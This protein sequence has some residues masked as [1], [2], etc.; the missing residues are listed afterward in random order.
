MD[1]LIAFI[2]GV[3]EGITEFVPISSTGHLIIIDELLLH[4]I[5]RLQSQEV[6]NTFKIVIQFGAVLAVIVTNSNQ[7][8][9]LV[10]QPF[11]RMNRKDYHLLH[12][13]WGLF[14]AIVVG[15]FLADFIDQYLF[16]LET[17]IIGLL[18][19]S[20]VMIVADRIGKEKNSDEIFT[21]KDAF[22]IGLYQCLALWPGVSRSGATISGGI[23][24]G[25]SYE[26]AANFTFIM[27]IPIMFGASSLS[28]YKNWTFITFDVLPFYI[29][30]FFSSFIFGWL[31]I[32]FFI[33]LIGKIKLKPFVIYRIFLAVFL[34]I[35]YMKLN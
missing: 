1:L 32:R 23:M 13:L 3:V 28:L 26:K 30:G 20:I 22:F 18:I 6:V 27:A 17:V 2:F 35:F 12:L 14:P 10:K 21:Y 16:R 29:I 15:F 8:I 34:I 7:L 31:S 4:S 24:Y 9:H 11:E 33:K 5:E 19:G 25:L